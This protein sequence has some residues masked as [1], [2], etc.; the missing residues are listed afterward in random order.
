MTKLEFIDKYLELVF[1][2]ISPDDTEPTVLVSKDT[3][4]YLTLKSLAD[5]DKL[6]DFLANHEITI[7]DSTFDNDRKYPVANIGYSAK[8]NKWYGWSH[9]AI[10]GF[11]IGSE[12]KKG[13]VAYRA[14]NKDDYKE[15]L[16]R[17]WTYDDYM[18][19]HH[20]DNVTDDDFDVVA[21]YT[22]NVPN[23]TLRG[24]EFRTNVKFPKDYGRGEWVAETIEDAKQM[25][26]DFAN[27]I[28]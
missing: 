12:V 18:E 16:L 27:N 8:E 1:S 24:T 4:R 25:A 5:D 21:T 9:R 7:I 2:E 13:H 3:K 15:D 20:T 6:L 19:K 28:S 23:E 11:T 10:Y 17:F 22:D 14:P 26:I